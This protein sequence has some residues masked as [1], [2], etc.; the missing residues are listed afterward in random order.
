MVD[1][2]DQ[3][4]KKYKIYQWGRS[5][6]RKISQILANDPLDAWEYAIGSV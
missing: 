6:S 2:I 4:R 5:I 1:R 3:R